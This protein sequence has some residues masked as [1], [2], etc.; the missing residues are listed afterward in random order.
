[1]SPDA[2]LVDAVFTGVSDFQSYQ[3]CPLGCDEPMVQWAMT[4]TS[5]GGFLS[6][7]KSP[8]KSHPRDHKYIYHTY[9]VGLALWA[10]ATIAF[11]RVFQKCSKGVVVALTQPLYWVAK[12]S[13]FL[14][15]TR[16]I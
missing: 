6:T 15:D 9:L 4:M 13:D 10:G 8:F 16:P 2:G 7:T 5:A 1:M 12:D 3:D 14:G 11:G